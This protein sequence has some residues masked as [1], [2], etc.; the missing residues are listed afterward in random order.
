M[1]VIF[2]RHLAICE[3]L[4]YLQNWKYTTYHNAIREWSEPRP[5]TTCTQN[6]A[7][8]GHAVFQLLWWTNKQT[9]HKTSHPSRGKVKI[10]TLFSWICYFVCT[11]VGSGSSGSKLEQP[12]WRLLQHTPS[13]SLAWWD[14][15]LMLFYF[16][17]W[18]CL[19]CNHVTN[20][21]HLWQV[22]V[23]LWIRKSV[24]KFLAV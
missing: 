19:Q 11:D 23:F 18:S 15:S 13:S 2:Y 20:V 9:D 17:L 5:Q 4:T 10:T 12:E 3:N 16:K 1:L 8:F 14:T 6:L 22:T 24:C 21:M 7:K